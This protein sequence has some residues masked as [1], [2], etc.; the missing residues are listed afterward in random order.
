MKKT[1]YL[2][3][4]NFFRNISLVLMIMLLGALS[5][6]GQGNSTTNDVRSSIN[7]IKNKSNE[8]AIYAEKASYAL[9][10][11][12]AEMNAKLAISIISEMQQTLAGTE[13]SLEIMSKQNNSEKYNRAMLNVNNGI[14]DLQ[15]KANY[16]NQQLTK[17]F[18]AKDSEDSKL[19]ANS[20]I[21]ELKRMDKTITEIEEEI[22][23]A[24]K[25]LTI[26][27]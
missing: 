25:S 7:I 14:V 9:T 5:V 16:T 11:K 24:E 10:F 12:D 26:A 17:L 22:L 19:L 18:T 20:A 27:D 2:S 6:Y 15:N 3:I 13:K 21:S 23:I 1:I 4:L 8:A